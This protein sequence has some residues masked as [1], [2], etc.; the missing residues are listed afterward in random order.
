MKE[1]R[2]TIS[3]IVISYDGMRFLP[4][5]LRT[6][7]DDLEGIDH[8]L[9]V[10][11]N[12]SVDG[13]AAFV[14]HEYPQ[15][16]LIENDT[17]LGFAKAVNIGLKTGK[18][19]FLYVL[20]QDLRFRKGSTGALLDRIRGDD[21]LG[22][23]GPAYVGFDG[24][25]QK[26]AR[27][28]PTYRHILYRAFLLDRLFPS[29]REFANWRMGWFDHKHERFVDQ[30][31]GAVMMIP[32]RVVDEIGLMDESFPILF[33]DVDYCKRMQLAGFKRLYYPKAVV[34]H[35]AGAST[36]RRPY[37]LKMISHMAMFRYLKKYTRWYE[38]PALWMCGVLLLL[39]LAPSIAGRF[40]RRRFTGAGSS[41]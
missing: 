37:R 23:I 14:R 10:V 17:N 38:Y 26:S 5:C 20:N 2:P 22:L 1:T 32:R 19:D 21:T 31:M 41:S 12:G 35:F 16:T 33:N 24:E 11:D 8:E 9:I 13:S 7:T 40:L 18:G 29:H 27:A 25:L 4:D 36:G 39:G 15:A 30:P 6:L 3:A 28:F 34:E